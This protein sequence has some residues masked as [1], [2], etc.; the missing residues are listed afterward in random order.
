ML[1]KLEMTRREFKDS[2]LADINHPCKFIMTISQ[3]DFMFES[4]IGYKV[5]DLVKDYIVVH[6]KTVQEKTN[7]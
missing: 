6:A 1:V 5:G 7:D 3:K 4:L 2:G